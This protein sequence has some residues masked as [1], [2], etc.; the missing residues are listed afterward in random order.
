[1]AQATFRVHLARWAF[2]AFKG[3]IRLQTLIRGHLITKQAIF[4]LC[5]TM[6]I[7]KQQAHARGV[8][9]RHSDGG[10]EVQKKCNQINLL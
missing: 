5:C 10:L 8:M 3:I 4:T 7:V 9:A 2:R 1:M 6:G